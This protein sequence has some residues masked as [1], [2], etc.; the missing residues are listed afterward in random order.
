VFL[1]TSEE[2]VCGTLANPCKFQ[3]R[4]SGLPSLTAYTVDFDTNI[5]EYVITFTGTGFSGTTS[6]VSVQVD[7]FE[8]SVTSVSST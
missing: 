5:N 8:Q 2:A 1:K 7:G 6:T 4:A 3:W